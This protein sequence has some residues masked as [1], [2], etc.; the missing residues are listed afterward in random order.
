MV[1]FPVHLEY[2]RFRVTNLQWLTSIFYTCFRKIQIFQ[3]S[4][5]MH[6]FEIKILLFSQRQICFISRTLSNLESMDEN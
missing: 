6:P 4:I 1:P 3:F 5:L 2:I